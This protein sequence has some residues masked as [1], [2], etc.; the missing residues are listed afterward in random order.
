MIAK[1][2]MAIVLSPVIKVLWHTVTVAPELNK[3]KVF[4]NGISQGLKTSTPNG[5]QTPPIS[6]VG[7]ILE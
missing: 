2:F 5:G 1:L 3:I 4:N 7:A 6:I